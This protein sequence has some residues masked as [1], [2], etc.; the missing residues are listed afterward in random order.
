[1]QKQP[2]IVHMEEE[3]VRVQ[4]AITRILDAPMVEQLKDELFN[5]IDHHKKDLIVDL[6]G[7]DYVSSAFLGA[8]IRCQRRL[9]QRGN[10]LMLDHVSD[11]VD[12]VLQISGISNLFNR[13]TH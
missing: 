11:R 9:R 13:V 12:Q 10:V 1:M 8:L 3:A 6:T 7:V 5:L 2:I 4:M